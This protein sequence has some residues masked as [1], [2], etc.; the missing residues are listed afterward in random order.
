MNFLRIRET[1]IVQLGRIRQRF[2]L[3]FLL[4]YLLGFRRCYGAVAASESR[5]ICFRQ[6]QYERLY[7]RGRLLKGLQ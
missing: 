6:E 4:L 1:F 5:T 2:V 3:L 7:S